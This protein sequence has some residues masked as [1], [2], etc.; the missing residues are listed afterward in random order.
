VER[1]RELLSPTQ[2]VLGVILAV[3]WSL[4]FVYAGFAGDAFGPLGGVGMALLGVFIFLRRVVDEYLTEP[5]EWILFGGFGT[6]L[7]GGTIVV[8]SLRGEQV[9]GDLVL[10]YVGWM[11]IAALFWYRATTTRYE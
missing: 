8:T 10:G 2:R 3:G 1:K 11:A 6:V 7:V 4:L 9:G 5:Q